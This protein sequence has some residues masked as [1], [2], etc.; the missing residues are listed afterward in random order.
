M[1]R[2]VHKMGNGSEESPH[3]NRGT[4]IEALRH[5]FGHTICNGEGKTKII[6]FVLRAVK[7]ELGKSTSFGVF[8]LKIQHSLFFF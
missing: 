2:D 1:C 6:D 7:G 4:R 3:R 5:Y 8:P